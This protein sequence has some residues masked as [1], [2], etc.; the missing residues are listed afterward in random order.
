MI[1][2]AKL[3]SSVPSMPHSLIKWIRYDVRAR[4]IFII[5]VF[6]AMT[7]CTSVQ[8]EQ[9][10]CRIL[11]DSPNHSYG[12]M[13]QR[14]TQACSLTTMADLIKAHPDTRIDQFRDT[15]FHVLHEYTRGMILDDKVRCFLYTVFRRVLTWLF[16]M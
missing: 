4:Q 14:D 1:S 7:G 2:V 8:A 6:R 3:R 5:D 9:D 10:L 15:L 16:V 11:Q 12:V 13:G